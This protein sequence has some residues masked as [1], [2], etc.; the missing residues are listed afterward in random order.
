MYYAE[1]VEESLANSEQEVFIQFPAAEM[2]PLHAQWTAESLQYVATQEQW[3]KNAL[4]EFWQPPVATT[5]EAPHDQPESDSDDEFVPDD[6]KQ[7]GVD[8]SNVEGDDNDSQD[9]DG[10]HL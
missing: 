7:S 6:G 3:M 4:Y 2:K 10:D 8:Q 9:S 1:K 5:A